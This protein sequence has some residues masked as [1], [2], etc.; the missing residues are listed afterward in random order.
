ME[1]GS[2]LAY[3]AAKH[4]LDRMRNSLSN[5]KQKGNVE[6]KNAIT[7]LDL[8]QDTWADISGLSG[9]APE[10]LYQGK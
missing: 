5:K 4:N 1:Y 9:M 6:R 3:R 10:P 2:F 8:I 7:Y